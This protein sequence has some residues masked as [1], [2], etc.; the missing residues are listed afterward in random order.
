[1]VVAEGT[2]RFRHGAEGLL[3]CPAR[4]WWPVLEEHGGTRAPIADVQRGADGLEG[5]G[6]AIVQPRN[7][8]LLSVVGQLPIQD[9]GVAIAGEDEM[10]GIWI[11]G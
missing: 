9:A 1:M 4:Y 7:E 10:A 8:L 5:V 6:L 3:N 2:A 11:S